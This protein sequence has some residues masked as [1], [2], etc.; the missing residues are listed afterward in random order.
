MQNILESQGRGVHFSKASG[1]PDNIS[2]KTLNL[3]LIDFHQDTEQKPVCRKKELAFWSF[4]FLHF[5]K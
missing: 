5:S 2:F 3:G 1:F 4:F